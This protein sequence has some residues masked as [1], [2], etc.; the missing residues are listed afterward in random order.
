MY[1]HIICISEK[2][3]KENVYI[4][5]LFPSQMYMCV[6]V[7]IYTHIYSLSDFSIIGYYKILSLVPCAI[8]Y[9]LAVC[10]FYT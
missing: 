4:Y 6:C 9:V 3:L 1:I 2:N 8:H 10:L 7:Y 5:F